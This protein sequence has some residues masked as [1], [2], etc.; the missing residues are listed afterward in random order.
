MESTILI[1]LHAYPDPSSRRRLTPACCWR[2]S[3]SVSE[4]VASAVSCER[5]RSRAVWRRWAGAC[6]RGEAC[7][8]RSRWD[9]GFHGR[10]QRIP[11]IQSSA[12]RRAGREPLRRGRSF[13]Y[14]ALRALKKVRRPSNGERQS[15]LPRRMG[16]A[17]ARPS[18]SVREAMGPANVLAVGRFGEGSCEAWE[19]HG[20]QTRPTYG[21][22]GVLF[23]SVP[24]M[25][26]PYS[27]GYALQIL[28]SSKKPSLPMQPA[29]HARSPSFTPDLLPAGLMVKNDG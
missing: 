13:G 5:P 4:R 23:E 16:V 19:A 20:R 2:D 17:T 1:V 24:M 29:A 22:N 6:E 28:R 18:A 21:R 15:M 8:S 9:E 27:T 14:A 10:A 7:D 11:T 26:C 3:L 25:H 12:C